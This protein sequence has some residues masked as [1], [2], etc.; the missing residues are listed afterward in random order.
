MTRILLLLFVVSTLLP[1]VR[2]ACDVETQ[3]T[4]NDGRCIPVYWRCDTKP[5]CDNGEDEISCDTA[6]CP[7]TYSFQCR[8]GKC[9]KTSWKCDYRINC[10][11]GD[12]EMGCA[13]HPDYHWQCNDTIC[14]AEYKRCDG[15]TDCLDGSDEIDCG[16]S[17]P[18]NQF[19][20]K[21][22]KCIDNAKV[23]NHIVDC[24][25]D[26][27]DEDDCPPSSCSPY[28]FQCDNGVCITGYLE[29]DGASNCKNGEDE[30][31][32]GPKC[33]KCE[34]WYKMGVICDDMNDKYSRPDCEINALCMTRYTNDVNGELLH[35]AGYMSS[36]DCVVGQNSNPVGCFEEPITLAEG[37]ECVFCCNADWCNLV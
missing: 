35:T 9:L 16:G 12:D 18:E 29:C 24:N 7:D 14:I 30:A 25:P 17:C 33:W 31:L 11:D 2:S 13:C 6:V 21:S 22:G 1:A 5:Q 28:Q 20:C 36:S 26:E 19:K 32:C 4:C 8:S 23:C 10:P 15:N 34:G 37:E 27:E 3:F